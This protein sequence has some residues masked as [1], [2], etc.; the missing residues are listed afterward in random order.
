VFPL[1]YNGKV[2]LNDAVAPDLSATTTGPISAAIQTRINVGLATD[3]SGSAVPPLT[4]SANDVRA[5]TVA[6]VDWRAPGGRCKINGFA[7]L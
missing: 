4:Y 1:R 2:S 6:M 7:Q 5:V 3:P